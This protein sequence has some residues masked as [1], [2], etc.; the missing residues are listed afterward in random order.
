MYSRMLTSSAPDRGEDIAP[1]PEMHPVLVLA[2]AQIAA[3]DVNGALVFDEPNYL[4]Y[5]VLG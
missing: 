5:G 4:S 2:L 1:D 3:G